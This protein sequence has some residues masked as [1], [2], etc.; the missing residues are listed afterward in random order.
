MM[1]GKSIYMLLLSMVLPCLLYGQLK[2]GEWRDHL[3]Y[4]HGETITIGDKKI[5][6]ASKNSLFLLNKDDNSLEK[7]SKVNGLSDIG[8]STIKY[9]SENDLLFIAYTNTNIDLVRGNQIFNISD[10]KRKSIP[11][12]KVI[13]NILFID[14]YAYLSCGFGIVVVNLEKREIKDTYYIGENGSPMEVF[15]L[16][17]NGNYLYAA[18]EKGILKADIN[19]PNLIY[20]TAWTRITGIPGSQNRFNRILSFNNRI[21]VNRSDDQLVTDTIYLFNGSAWEIFDSR[22]GIKNL[23]FTAYQ[24]KL[25]ISSKG[26]LRIYNNIIQLEREIDSYIHAV[27]NAMD[28][29]MDEDGVVWIADNYLGIVKHPS[30]GLFESIYPNGPFTEEVSD[31]D[32]SAGN[33][34]LAGGG[35]DA[36]WTGIFNIG[37][38]YTYTDGIWDNILDYS[39]RDVVRVLSDPSNPDIF[40]AASWGHGLLEYHE[41]TLENHFK[42]GEP[43]TL[44]SIIPGDDYVRIGGMAFDANHNLWMTNSGVDNPVSVRKLDG[45]WKSFPYGNVINAPTISDIIVTYYDHKWILLPRGFGLFAFDN[46]GTIDDLNDDRYKKFS[47]VD[48]DGNTI[49]DVYSIAEDLDGNIWVGTN[50]GPVVYYSPENLFSDPDFRA[51]RIKVPRNDGSDLADYLLA[52]ETIT[53]IA[54]DGANRKWIGTDGAGAF[55]LSEDGLQE[56]H[57][58]NETNSPLLSNHITTIAI[59]HESGEVFFGTDQGVVSYRSTATEGSD[60]FS[61]VYVFPNPVREDYYG[62]ITITGLVTDVNVKITDISGNIV[63]ETTALGGQAIWD[64]RTFSGERVHTGVYLIFSTNEDGSKTHVTKVLF[65]H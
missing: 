34:R 1:K 39:I 60:D 55:L 25:F 8:I 56:I 65:I 27:P 43:S 62:P 44:E 57:N 15:Q 21:L 12:N 46:N 63:Y 36:G 26:L 4:S 51:Q 23:S 59:D 53:S 61:N 20:Y 2:I 64:G 9:S 47:V 16:A 41:G 52:T 40:F 31:M 3:P 6:C 35:R 58:F 11:G 42:E 22:D 18:T 17:L 45:T 14:K 28:A 13:N 38:I 5:Y 24:N 49:N 10:I 37:K 29:L 19:S 54:V 33:L 48:Q 32:I 50:Q 7:L 30:P